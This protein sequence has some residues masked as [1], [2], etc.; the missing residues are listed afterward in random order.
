M[1]VSAA[2]K[3]AERTRQAPIRLIKGASCCKKSNINIYPT[4]SKGN[5]TVE[6]NEG[7]YSIEIYSLT[8]EKVFEKTT[9]A[10]VEHLS[11]NVTSG[12]YFVNIKKDNKNTIKKIVIQ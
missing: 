4:V 2:E 10:T 6:V 3:K 9:N 1:A 5:F 12:L 11:L 8:G 7:A